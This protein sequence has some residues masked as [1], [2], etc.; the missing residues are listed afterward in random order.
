MTNQLAHGPQPRDA[1][2]LREARLFYVNLDAGPILPHNCYHA[3][4]EVVL[5]SIGY[6]GPH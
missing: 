6:S 4:I 5:P 1:P 3:R 2:K